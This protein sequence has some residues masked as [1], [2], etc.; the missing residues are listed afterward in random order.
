MK[1]GIATH[2]LLSNYGGI[3]QNFALQQV[4]KKL[5]HEPVTIDFVPEYSVYKYVRSLCK[6]LLLLFIPWKRR[7]F[8]SY[9]A[10][11]SRNAKVEDFCRK[12]ITLTERVY[13]YMPD[14]VTCYNM[15]AVI[16]GSDQVW[17]ARYNRYPGYIEDMFLR[18]VKESS[19]KK[20]AYAA[21]FGIDEWDY[22]PE[23]TE[24]CKGYAALFTSISVRE[25]SGVVLCEKHLHVKAIEVL[26]PTL[27]L[28]QVDYED[29]CSEVPR[30][31]SRFM[32]AYILDISQG[33]RKMINDIARKK[34]LTVKY[35]SAHQNMK[36]SIEEWLAMFRDT[37]FVVTDSFH[38]TVFSILFNKPFLTIGNTSRGMARFHSLL[39]VFDLQNRLCEVGQ[40]FAEVDKIDWEKVNGRRAELKAHSLDFLRILE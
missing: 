28:E 36:L 8:V 39:N 29:V 1:I 33:K 16:V 34:G 11:G 12:H 14:I 35:F 13:R 27:L 19:V 22:L 3:L 5:G 6:T 31:T 25:S 40:E 23:M 32:A 38:G 10:M 30:D 21:S 20:L 2:P 24:R 37:K 15:K 26:D 9:R 4:L 7:P 18:F 17:R